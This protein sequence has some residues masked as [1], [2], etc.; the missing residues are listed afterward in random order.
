MKTWTRSRFKH[1]QWWTYWV[2][3]CP[4]GVVFVGMTLHFQGL[5]LE[6]TEVKIPK[7]HPKVS[8][9]PQSMNCGHPHQ[10]S[11]WSP[12]RLMAKTHVVRPVLT[13]PPHTVGVLWNFGRSERTGRPVSYFKYKT[14]HRGSLQ[15]EMYFFIKKL[16][17]L[18]LSAWV[19]I[20]HDVKW[21]AFF[22][23]TLTDSAHKHKS[24]FFTPSNFCGFL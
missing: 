22:D 13:P 6:K 14:Y 11:I 15:P 16:N 2:Y 23:R 12:Q 10:T 19:I 4:E 5:D 17:L 8:H 20:Q 18:M 24:K 1:R 21:S 9:R 7:Q 3:H